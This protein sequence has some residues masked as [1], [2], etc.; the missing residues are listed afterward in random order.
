VRWALAAESAPAAPVLEPVVVAG[1]AAD[2]SAA[3][4]AA[5]RAHQRPGTYTAAN[6]SGSA[7]SW[8]AIQASAR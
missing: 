1:A 7:M 4:D 3:R 8:D 2:R 5:S 6:R